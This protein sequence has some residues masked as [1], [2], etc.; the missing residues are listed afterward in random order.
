MSARAYRSSPQ[1]VPARRAPALDREVL[2]AG[3][4]V[5]IAALVDVVGIA[6][7]GAAYSGLHAVALVVA[8][9]L[10][11]AIARA[12]VRRC[13]EWFRARVRTTGDRA[14]RSS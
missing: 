2:F 8:V 5:W 14:L 1:D 12:V 9:A 13:H 4:I 3:A 6:A 10:G 7:R 11:L